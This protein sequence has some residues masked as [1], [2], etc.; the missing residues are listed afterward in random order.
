MNNINKNVIGFWLYIITDCI[1]FSTIFLSFLISKHIFFLKNII[2]NYRIILIETI[3]LLLSSFLTIKII[4]KSN[5]K[6]YFLNIF[7][8]ILFLIIEL[9][10]IKHLFFLNLSFKLNNYLSNY[11]LILFFHALHVF[12]AIIICINLIL[13]NKLKYK[14]KIINIIFLIFW[15]IIHIIWLCLSFIIYI[16]K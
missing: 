8:S 9:K 13:L 16:K 12:V 5:I 7:F 15:H 10:D 6:Y 4:N 11:Y 1:M 2:Y 14:F 3:L